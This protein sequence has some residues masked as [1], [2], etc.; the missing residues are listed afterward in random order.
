[1]EPQPKEKN[2]YGYQTRRPKLNLRQV[3]T[4]DPLL[5]QVGLDRFC[6]YTA[7]PGQ[8]PEF[9]TQ[10]PPAGLAA[11]AK[12]RIAL[13]PAGEP[14]LDPASILARH[15]LDQASGMASGAPAIPESLQK[16]VRLVFIDTQADFEGV[17]QSVSGTSKR[18][19]SL[20]HLADQLVCGGVSPC[21]IELATRLALPHENRNLPSAT[22]AS[23]QGGNL[24]LVEELAAAI[25]RE[26]WSWRQSGS[27]QNLILNLSVGWDDE[28][29][30]ELDQPRGSQL[31][32][33][34]QLVYNALQFARR[35]GALVIAAAGNLRGGEQPSSSPLLPAAW[36]L[37]NPFYSLFAFSRKPVY[38]VGGVDWQGLPLPN[39]RHG[40]LP[41]RVAF[42]DHAVAQTRGSAAQT[43]MYTGSSVS[44]AV[45]SSIAAVVWQLRP[46]LRPAQ[47]MRL[48]GRS[49]NELPS[50]AD[51]YAWKDLWLISDLVPAP[52]LRR[53]SVC[54][55][56]TRACR[57]GRC[58]APE[59][60]P[61]DPEH[62]AAQLAAFVHSTST[63][64]IAPLP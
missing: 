9:P 31:R 4:A 7:K 6:A 45:V 1:M 12:G 39:A 34:T 52:H 22:T 11:P 55:A 54:Q 26:V 50:R 56:I 32:P 15:F 63:A 25:V 42:G 16:P 43:A 47:G 62:G 28:L 13:V 37:S 58:Y 35:S 14:D 5:R 18:G 40:G 23:G 36:E 33:D 49:G 10:P 38:A 46:E 27:K 60:L 59:C 2:P 24:G 19:Y 61:W 29:L 17:P 51:Y 20:V 48:I 44:T 57:G 21:G 41:R 64:A 3:V 53:L 30:G 8:P